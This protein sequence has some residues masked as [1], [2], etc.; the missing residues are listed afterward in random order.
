MQLTGKGAGR[1]LAGVVSALVVLALPLVGASAASAGDARVAGTSTSALLLDGLPQPGLALVRGHLRRPGRRPG[2]GRLVV[3]VRHVRPAAQRRTPGTSSRCR[4]RATSCTGSTPGTPSR[5]TLPSWADQAAGR[6]MWAPDVHYAD[7]Q[8]R[9]Y[10]VVTQTTGTRPAGRTT[11]PSAWRRPRRRSGRG[12]TAAPRSSARAGR[13]GNNFLWTFDP[14]VGAGRRRHRAHLLRLVL[15]RGLPAAARHHGHAGR[16]ATRPGSRS[17]T[18]SRAPT[19]RARTA[20]GTSSAPRPT[21]APARRPATAS[22][23]PGRGR[24]PVPTWTRTGCASTSAATPA[25]P[26]CSTR[27]ATAGSGPATTRWR[28]TTAGSGGSS[29]TRSTGTTRSST[30]P[31]GIN[32]RPMLIDRIDWVRGW[33]VVRYGCG[34]SDSVQRGPA[35]RGPGQGHHDVG[36]PARDCLEALASIG[37]GRL[38]RADSDEFNGAALAPAGSP[39]AHPKSRSAA[40]RSTGPPSATTSSGPANTAEHAAARTPRRGTGRSRPS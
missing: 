40:A 9:M 3:R 24:S 14:E 20:T 11:T 8:W 2:Q 35:V 7:G 6:R 21:A 1:P 30:R 12:R 27:T 15:R 26:R 39:C 13:S 10:Y 36:R 17:T 34:P 31:Y 19:S 37:P 38:D 22:R 25:G 28:P 33:P 29:T 5:G 16:P 4:S 32:R 23:S 18:S